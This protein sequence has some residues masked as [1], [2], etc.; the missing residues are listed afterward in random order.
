MTT[1]VIFDTNYGNTRILAERIAQQLGDARAL[2]VTDL[3]PSD[4]EGV[5]LLVAGSPIIGWKPSERMQAFLSTLH[6]GSLTGVKAAAFDTR[7][8]LFIH[9]DAARKISRALSGAGAEIVASP[10]G[11]IVAGTKGP[12]VEG[13]LARAARWADT[14]LRK[15][16]GSST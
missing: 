7:V 1:L 16:A 4:L 2:S 6:E 13:E 3:S 10:L 9:G 8:R 14:F 5:D 12:L 15:V 11:F